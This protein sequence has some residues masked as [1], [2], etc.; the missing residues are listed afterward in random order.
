MCL[1]GQLGP[2]TRP[3][4][5]SGHPRWIKQVHENTQYSHRYHL[6]AVRKMTW[7]L[8]D[9]SRC[10]NA[11][12]RRQIGESSSYSLLMTKGFA[13]WW[14]PCGCAMQTGPSRSHLRQVSNRREEVRYISLIP[15]L[16]WITIARPRFFLLF[17]IILA[18]MRFNVEDS[19]TAYATF[20]IR[21]ATSNCR[22]SDVH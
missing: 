15:K 22:L 9:L 7:D 13:W 21:Q 17:V 5:H 3:H 10:L 11:T 14:I 1:R 20:M 16:L 4:L 19:H 2:A 8:P 6:F 18:I 12:P